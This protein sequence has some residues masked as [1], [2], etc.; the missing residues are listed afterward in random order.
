M[1]TNELMELCKLLK[2][3]K[4]E[5]GTMSKPYVQDVIVLATAAVSYSALRDAEGE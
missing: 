4:N 3:F 2:Q 1:N 5:L